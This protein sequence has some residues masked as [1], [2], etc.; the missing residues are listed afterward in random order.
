MRTEIEEEAQSKENES[1]ICIHCETKYTSNLCPKCHPI[2]VKD[3]AP[4]K[5]RGFTFDKPP[6][7]PKC[8]HIKA[9]TKVVINDDI[10][11]DGTKREVGDIHLKCSENCGWLGIS[12]RI[13]L[14]NLEFDPKVKRVDV[15][16]L[17]NEKPKAN[18]G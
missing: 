17:E 2:E 8:E 15:R 3:W 1:L 11:I 12:E 16:G 13:Y 10:E 7:I 14:H 6:E 4:L 5:A 9:V 18:T